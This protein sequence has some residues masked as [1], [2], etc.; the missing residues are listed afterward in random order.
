M[1]AQ[2]VFYTAENKSPFGSGS[3]PSPESHSGS[4]WPCPRS[5]IRDPSAKR[6]LAAPA[7]HRAYPVLSVGFNADTG[8]RRLELSGGRR[9]PPTRRAHD[10][11]RRPN[12]AVQ[13]ASRRVGKLGSSQAPSAQ[14]A[15]VRFRS[16]LCRSPQA[17]GDLPPVLGRSPSLQSLYLNATP[18]SDIPV[19]AKLPALRILDLSGTQVSL[20]RTDSRP[21]TSTPGRQ[22]HRPVTVLTTARKSAQKAGDKTR[23]LRTL[24]RHVPTRPPTTSSREA[25]PE[26]SP[27]SGMSSLEAAACQETT[28][29]RTRVR[30]KEPE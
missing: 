24:D 12:A 25:A 1:P 18:V 17:V 14:Q 7:M 23:L 5:C 6:R 21:A 19:L 26:H 4:G 15:P 16:V 28:E 11:G 10:P 8:R 13:S 27:G 22:H 9:S 20:R 29:P 30:G 2:P 3:R